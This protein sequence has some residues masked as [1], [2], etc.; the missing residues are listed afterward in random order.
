IASTQLLQGA[1]VA[2]RDSAIHANAPCGIRLAP[3]PTNPDNLNQIIPLIAPPHYN[4]G[5]V[6]TWPGTDYSALT[7]LP[8]LVIEQSPGTWVQSGTA[9]I[10]QTNAP[11]SWFFNIRL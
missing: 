4:E 10:F 11:T 2:A 8:C 5:M 6:S 3:D 7:T 1:L 9:W